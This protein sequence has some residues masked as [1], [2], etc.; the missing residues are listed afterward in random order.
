M[1][2]LVAL[3]V[4]VWAASA[5]PTPVV[6]ATGGCKVLTALLRLFISLNQT[7]HVKMP[8]VTKNAKTI[9]NHL[10][11]LTVVLRVPSRRRGSWQLMPISNVDLSTVR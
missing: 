11:P 6:R 3:P 5:L 9:N 10:V 2:V 7:P 8:M 1:A 4:E